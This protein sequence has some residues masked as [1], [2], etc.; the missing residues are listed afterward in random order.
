MPIVF[1]RHARARNYVLRL[2]WNKTVV[3]T[4]PKN[5]ST[6]FAEAFVNS[7]KAWL[8]RQWKVLESRKIPPQVLQ[9]GMEVLFRGRSVGLAVARKGTEWQVNFGTQTL[10]IPAPEQNLRPFIEAHMFELAQQELAER[11]ATLAREHGAVVSRVVVRN[12]KSRWGSCS[13]SG[14][15]SLNWRLIQLPAQVR[16]Y[17]IVHELMHL[18]ELNHSQRFWNH[19]ARACPDYQGAEDWLKQNSGLVGF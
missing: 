8:E 2:H 16:D 10:S 14:T 1:R 12:Q 17:I 15:I 6:K 11:V 19:V 4:M 9:P 7:R 13:Y 18:R 5:G 3:V